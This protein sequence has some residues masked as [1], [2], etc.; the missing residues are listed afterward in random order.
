L[1]DPDEFRPWYVPC[2]LLRWL[3]GGEINFPSM[4]I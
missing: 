1:V 2:A 4:M 3:P